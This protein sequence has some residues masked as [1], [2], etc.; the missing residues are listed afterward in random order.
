MLRGME[1]FSTIVLSFD[2]PNPKWRQSVFYLELWLLAVAENQTF[3]GRAA[4]GIRNISRQAGE[5]NRQN[6]SGS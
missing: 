1:R 3:P 6:Q 5:E 4:A 2:V